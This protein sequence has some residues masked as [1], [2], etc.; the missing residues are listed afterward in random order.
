MAFF[1]ARPCAIDAILAPYR[2]RVAPIPALWSR[3]AALGGC[4]SAKRSA[5]LGWRSPRL[6]RSLI[7][8]STWSAMPYA[9][10]RNTGVFP[11]PWA[12]KPAATRLPG[13][14]PACIDSSSVIRW[15]LN[16]TKR[17][18]DDIRTPREATRT[19]TSMRNTTRTA[20]IKP[21]LGTVE[22]T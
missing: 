11:W 22:E 9:G 21:K 13:S 15:L 12:Q 20:A 6:Q 19:T 7:R 5:R 17:R 4:R 14:R 18:R 16:A 3:D 8:G 2:G 10:V 1:K